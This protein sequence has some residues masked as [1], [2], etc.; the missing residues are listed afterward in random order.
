MRQGVPGV[1]LGQAARLRLPGD[2]RQCERGI[3]D[4]AGMRSLQCWKF[5][6]FVENLEFCSRR[7][8]VSVHALHNYYIHSLLL[9][10]NIEQSPREGCAEPSEFAF[11]E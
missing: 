11:V 8:G 1:L 9:L 3:V 5:W 2:A 6:Y 7:N 10:S 4:A